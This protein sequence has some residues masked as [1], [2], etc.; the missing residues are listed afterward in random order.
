MN[1]LE[2][3]SKKI[4]YDVISKFIERLFQDL[5]L[6]LQRH[7]DATTFTISIMGFVNVTKI[8]I[9]ETIFKER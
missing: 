3:L 4:Y 7:H 5:L 2:D 6:I 1:K 8:K 9:N